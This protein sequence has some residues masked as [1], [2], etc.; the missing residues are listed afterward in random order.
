M[1]VLLL[2]CYL[3]VWTLGRGILGPVPVRGRAVR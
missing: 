2:S 3:V 1:S